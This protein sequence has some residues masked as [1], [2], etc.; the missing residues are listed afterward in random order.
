MKNNKRGR[1]MKKQ[2]MNFKDDLEEVKNGMAIDL[3]ADEPGEAEA[4]M[5]LNAL[6]DDQEELQQEA[7]ALIDVV[8]EGEGVDGTDEV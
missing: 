5:V 6:V 7:E 3:L 1:T 4:A 8:V 2:R